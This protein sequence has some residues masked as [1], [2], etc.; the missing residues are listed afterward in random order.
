MQFHS[1]PACYYECSVTGPP[2]N[3]GSSDLINF[4]SAINAYSTVDLTDGVVFIAGKEV[5]WWTSSKIVAKF[6][7]DEW[8]KLPDLKQGRSWHGSIQIGSKTVIIGGLTDDG[9][10]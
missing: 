7:N 10:G 9:E 5:N 4:L 8:S 3:S 2:Q 6:A 1:V